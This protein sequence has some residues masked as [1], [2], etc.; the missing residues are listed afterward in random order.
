MQQSMIPWEF[1]GILS[2]GNQQKNMKNYL[3]EF[4]QLEMGKST[5]VLNESITQQL[6]S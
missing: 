2:M 4:S 1:M 3:W 6:T 5:D